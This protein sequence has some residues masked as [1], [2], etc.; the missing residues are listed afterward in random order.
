M[1][2]VGSIIRLS[3]ILIHSEAESD[4]DDKKSLCNAMSNLF[5]SLHS[6]DNEV[7]IQ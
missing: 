5:S 4:T 2:H 3:F 1:K 6:K 7:R